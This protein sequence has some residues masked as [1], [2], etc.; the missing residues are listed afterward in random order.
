MVITPLCSR[1]RRVSRRYPADCCDVRHVASYLFAA[2]V[3]YFLP[4]SK[5]K[6]INRI[7]KFPFSPFLYAKSHPGKGMASE[8]CAPDRTRT[9]TTGVT[10]S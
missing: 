1:R 8:G 4:T 2:K 6:S 9:Y 5:G 7:G 10:R 3:H